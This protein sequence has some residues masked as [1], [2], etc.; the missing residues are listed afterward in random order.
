MKGGEEFFLEI[1]ENLEKVIMFF[2]EFRKI[3]N[4]VYFRVI[5]NSK[6]IKL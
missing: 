1:V 2:K 5:I 3:L 4:R 6:I